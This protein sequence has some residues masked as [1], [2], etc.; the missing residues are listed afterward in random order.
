MLKRLHLTAA[1]AGFL[2]ILT[3]WLSTV[4]VELFGSDRQIIA[5]KQAIPGGF[6]LLVPALVITG[7]TGFRM[8]GAAKA[9]RIR[10]KKR[11][12]PFIAGNGLVVLIPAALYL[13]R[14]PAREEFGAAFYAV[15]AL[16][17]IAGAVNLTLMSLNV[18]DGLRLSGRRSGAHAKG[19]KTRSQR[20]GAG[21]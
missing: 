12:M 21:S 5:V 3:F 9:P 13:D 2:T 17:L 6:L 15:Q 1:T 18:R 14:L 16:E 19:R 20:T 7:V 11:R 10:A 8:S 4:T